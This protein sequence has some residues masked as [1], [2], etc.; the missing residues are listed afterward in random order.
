M[1]IE[2]Y[3]MTGLPNGLSNGAL[4]NVKQIAVQVHLKKPE[5]TIEFL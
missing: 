1:D 4:K 3:K 2:G 5:R